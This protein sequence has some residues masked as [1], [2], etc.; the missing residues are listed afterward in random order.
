M[1]RPRII[2]VLLLKNNALIKTKKFKNERYIGDPINA[3]RIFNALKADEI[4]FLDIQAS[5]KGQPISLELVK[6]VGEEAY[7]PFSVGGGIKT[8]KQMEERIKAGAEKIVLGSLLFEQPEKIKDT[9]R[10]FGSSTLIGCMD[11]KKDWKG[12][13]SVFINNGKKK[14]QGKIEELARQ[15]EDMGIGELIVQSIEADGMMQGYNIPLIKRIA[16]AVKIPVTALGGAADLTS[17]KN[18][19][20]EIPVNG[21]AA[22]SMFVFSGARHGVLINYPEK[23]DIENNFKFK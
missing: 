17:M 22:G 11:I 5:K 19:F 16:E 2:P 15:I 12:K 21:L 9:V 8:L 20:E 7:M 23:K 18:L 4:I 13:E 3:V 1:Y 14:I 6:E 10:E